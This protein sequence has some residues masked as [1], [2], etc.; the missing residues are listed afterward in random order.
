MKN[1]TI[2]RDYF[3]QEGVARHAPRQPFSQLTR[4]TLE[5]VSRFIAD[6]PESRGMLTQA[7][8]SL[9]PARKSP[10]ADTPTIT[11]ESHIDA[12]VLPND[13]TNKLVALG[14]QP[15]GFVRFF[16]THFADH[17]T[18]KFKI[19]DTPNLRARRQH[20]QSILEEQ[21][22]IA[23]NLLNADPRIAEAYVE[24]EKYPSTNKQKWDLLL[25]SNWLGAFPFSA[26]AFH[27]IDV[28]QTQDQA[29]AQGIDHPTSLRKHSDIHIKI[30]RSSS[31][32]EE[33]TALIYHL[34]KVGFYPVHTWSGNDVCT[35]QFARAEDAKR[36]F[37][38][39]KHYFTRHG[40][41]DEMAWEVVTGMYRT[42]RHGC[43]ATVPPL[44]TLVA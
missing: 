36:V 27:V 44:V 31:R 25:D 10:T 5:Q 28:P 20:L 2:L 40:G 19:P 17:L 24:L 23:F 43:F 37:K 26:G 15:D 30:A 8:W 42:E 13:I 4:D 41:C 22:R 38:T 33:H 16:P 21:S 9:D 1:Y 29:A 6:Y 14:F 32:P 11:F 35:A 3:L 12:T 39:L 34:T 7:L 18:L